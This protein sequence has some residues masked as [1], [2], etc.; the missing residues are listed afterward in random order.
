MEVNVERLRDLMMERCLSV[1]QLAKKAHISECT[2][3]LLLKHNGRRKAGLATVGKIAHALG[4]PGKSLL[5]DNSL[6]FLE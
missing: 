6:D 4:V 2:L 5:I 1:R 3:S